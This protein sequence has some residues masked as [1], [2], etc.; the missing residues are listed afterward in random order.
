MNH[1]SPFFPQYSYISERF[2]YIQSIAMLCDLHTCFSITDLNAPLLNGCNEVDENTITVFWTD[3]GCTPDDVQ[4]VVSVTNSTHSDPEIH[5]TN[6]KNITLN[7]TEGFNY[8]ITVT[9]QRCGE[10]VT[11][12][13]SEPLHCSASMVIPNLCTAYK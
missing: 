6:D 7:I 4:Y 1:Y 9:T 5:V 13:S 2:F 8:T 10:T 3:N 11:S 12:D